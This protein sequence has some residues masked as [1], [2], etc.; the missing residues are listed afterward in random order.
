MI[1][2]RLVLYN[3]DSK[4]FFSPS[5]RAI[6]LKYT[7]LK[8]YNKEFTDSPELDVYRVRVSAG[9]FVVLAQLGAFSSLPDADIKLVS[10]PRV[11]LAVSMRDT[12][13]PSTNLARIPS[14][15]EQDASSDSGSNSIGTAESGD[16]IIDVM[17]SDE[18]DL[19]NA[20]RIL[21]AKGYTL[22]VTAS[23]TRLATRQAPAI[24]CVRVLHSFGGRV[25]RM[26]RVPREDDEL[27]SGAGRRVARRTGAAPRMQGSRGEAALGDAGV[28]LSAELGPPLRQV[29]RVQSEA[30]AV[31]DKIRGSSRAQCGHGDH[32]SARSVEAREAGGGA[33]V[34]T[35]AGMWIR[36]RGRLSRTVESG[37]RVRTEGVEFPGIGSAH[38]I[39]ER[40]LLH[41]ALLDRY[42]IR[43]GW[44]AS[45]PGIS[46]SNA[47][48][49]RAHEL[50]ARTTQD[51]GQNLCNSMDLPVPWLAYTHCGALG[52]KDALG[53]ED[54]AL[55]L[56]WCRKP[57]RKL[58]GR[59]GVPTIACV[60]EYNFNGCLSVDS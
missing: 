45:A 6:L 57:S 39:E 2:S 23:L 19:V 28:A 13:L 56:H 48:T 53:L 4:Q 33:R 51:L 10:I 9:N 25:A 55:C 8:T 22:Q 58:M 35:A 11:I 37:W 40:T 7:Q 41:G 21:A 43:S 15:S 49:R 14:T 50:R 31:Q 47:V 29:A 26:L 18:E 12:S 46:E 3:S 60:V 36:G 59:E 20:H 17:D 27:Y 42:S 5:T 1:T 54:A 32:E 52:S 24:R 30:R 16:D 44:W 38:S 34:G